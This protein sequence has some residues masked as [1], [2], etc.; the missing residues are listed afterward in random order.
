MINL[1]GLKINRVQLI[2]NHGKAQHE[3]L[4]LLRKIEHLLEVEKR[5]QIHLRVLRGHQPYRVSLIKQKQELL[6]KSTQLIGEFRDTP[7]RTLVTIK[8]YQKKLRVLADKN[9]DGFLC[10]TNGY[11]LIETLKCIIPTEFRPGIISVDLCVLFGFPTQ[12][13]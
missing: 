7:K 5:T 10:E 3:V 11:I 6:E 9:F 4:E 8:R 2:G 1:I 12:N 13:Q